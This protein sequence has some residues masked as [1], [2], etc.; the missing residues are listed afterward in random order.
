MK[1]MDKPPRSAAR[2]FS[3]RL[4]LLDGTLNYSAF[5]YVADDATPF[6]IAVF[7]AEV[8]AKTFAKGLPLASASAQPTDTNRA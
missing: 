5:Q 3:I 6:D 1:N 4:C 8:M 2:L 7:L